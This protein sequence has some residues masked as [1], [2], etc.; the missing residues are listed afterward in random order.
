MVEVD[1]S[2]GLS[3]HTGEVPLIDVFE[4][5]SQL[6]ASYLVTGGR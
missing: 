1:G 2:T 6:L 4:G 5:R 3:A